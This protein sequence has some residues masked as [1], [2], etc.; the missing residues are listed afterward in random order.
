MRCA[1]RSYVVADLDRGQYTY[2]AALAS[3]RYCTK[4][5]RYLVMDAR[6][7]FA[8]SYHSLAA[9]RREIAEAR[10]DDSANDVRVIDA[11]EGCDF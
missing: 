7:D 11:R 5:L 1:C 4:S 9:A 2:D 6:G 8:V 3:G 10:G